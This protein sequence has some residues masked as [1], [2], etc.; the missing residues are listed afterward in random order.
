[1]AQ[2]E[3]AIDAHELQQKAVVYGLQGNTYVTVN[4]AIVTAKKQAQATD[5]ILVCGSVFLVGE[6]EG[7]IPS[8]VL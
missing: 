3:R 4:E 6:I 1:M 5:L 8:S 7:I 2:I